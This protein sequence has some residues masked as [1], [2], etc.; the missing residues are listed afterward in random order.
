MRSILAVSLLVLS[1]Q[2]PAVPQ[3]HPQP[4]GKYCTP[5]GDVV[6]G[7]PTKDNPCKCKRHDQ[8]D[9]DDPDKAEKGKMC[10]AGEA[11]NPSHD[12][13][14]RKECIEQYCLCPV[15]C[16]VAGHGPQG[17]GTAPT[18]SSASPAANA[19]TAGK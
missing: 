13:I 18:K 4:D 19:G 3:G 17:H 8:V 16:D 12:T 11:T 2:T 15:A 9:A 10:K 6:K 7:R 14:C 5:T 1:I